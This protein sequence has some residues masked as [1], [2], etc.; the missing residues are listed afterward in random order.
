MLASSNTPG[1]G[2]EM[3][4]T[5]TRTAIVALVAAASFTGVSAIPAVS[6]AAVTA[7]ECHLSAA[8]TETPAPEQCN[9]SGFPTENEK[10][11][12]QPPEG[13]NKPGE[14]PATDPG[15]NNYKEPEIHTGEAPSEAEPREKATSPKR[16]CSAYQARHNLCE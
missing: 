14:S 7:E 2:T 8:S 13:E 11:E 6:Q 15:A 10:G 9:G 3:L 12:L 1:G 16:T 5:K 4:S